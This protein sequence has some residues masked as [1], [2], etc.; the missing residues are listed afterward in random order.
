METETCNH[1]ADKILI[2]SRQCRGTRCR[3]DCSPSH[4]SSPKQISKI[5]TE[6]HAGIQLTFEIAQTCRAVK[7]KEQSRNNGEKGA[8]QSKMG[9][10]R[11]GMRL[12]WTSHEAR[13]ERFYIAPWQRSMKAVKGQY[14]NSRCDIHGLRSTCFLLVT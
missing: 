2:L 4:R 6:R 12:V 11:D 3:R 14:V 7:C 1:E 9:R 5:K 8:H 10:V 13:Q